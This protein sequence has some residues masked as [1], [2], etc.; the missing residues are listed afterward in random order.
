MKKVVLTVSLALAVLA[1]TTW[2]S[3]KSKDKQAVE[4]EKQQPLSI[5][6]N[7]D[8]FNASFRNMLKAYYGV[9]DALFAADTSRAS[10]AALTL[11]QAAD[12]LQLGQIQGDTSGTIKE[13]AVIYAGTISGSARGLAGETSLDNKRKEF[14]MI[15][16]ALWTLVRIVKYNGEKLYWDYCPMAFDNKGAYWVSD[17]GAIKNPYFGSQMP[18]CGSIEDSVDYSKK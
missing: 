2:C 18:T 13:N 16:D 3:C 14:A 4:E 17:D 9:K 5:G 1:I 12:S 7:T 11:A 6:N 10:A 15:A 8:A